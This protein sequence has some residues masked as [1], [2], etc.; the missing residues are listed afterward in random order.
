MVAAAYISTDAS[1][2]FSQFLQAL[3]YTARAYARRSIVA[4]HMVGARTESVTQRPEFGHAA[5]GSFIESS[6]ATRKATLACV[7]ALQW[8][9]MVHRDIVAGGLLR[10]YLYD[11]N[12]STNT[13]RIH[14]LHPSNIT[15][16]KPEQNST[17][18]HQN[19]HHANASFARAR[20]PT[21]CV[22]Q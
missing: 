6:A 2:K 16:S 21:Y 8:Q 19:H 18:W 17:S 1:E 9:E 3:S 13:V 5:V 10:L 22:T 15:A 20:R 12:Y 11:I 14:A 7:L 4:V